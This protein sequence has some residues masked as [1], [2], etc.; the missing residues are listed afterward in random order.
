[1]L[2]WL[3]RLYPARWRDRYGGELQQLVQDLHPSR[4]TLI[5]AIDL[6]KGALN[7][8]LQERLTMQS[9]DRKAAKRAA[10][11]AG[12]VWLGLSAEIL[13]TNVVFP[14]KTDNDTIP[15]LVSTCAYS[16]RSS[17]SAGSPPGPVPA[18]RVRCSPGSSPA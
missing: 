4:P 11:I 9:A 3:I 12:I 10:L 18:A 16:L 17:S 1:M 5:L 7:A 6:V 15:V 8:H 14:A 13:L 2:E